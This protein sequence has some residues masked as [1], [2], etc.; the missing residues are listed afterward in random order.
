MICKNIAE[1]LSFAH[2]NKIVHRDLK[3]DN[4]LIGK[5]GVAKICDFGCSTSTEESNGVL[6]SRIGSPAYWDRRMTNGDPYDM[7]VDIYALG[8]IFYSI[9]KGKG[10]YDECSST[11]TM[12]K[13]RSSID[14]RF[15]ESMEELMVGVPTS[16][17]N[18]I[19]NCLQPDYTQRF[20]A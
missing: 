12:E 4:I 17:K 20:A 15:E 10:I 5:G 8:M 6:A 19:K 3:P 2:E 14:A 1:G 16:M 13:L 9:F 7:T 11:F 18:I